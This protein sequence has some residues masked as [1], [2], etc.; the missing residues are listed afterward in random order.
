[1]QYQVATLLRRRCSFRHGMEQKRLELYSKGTWP[2]IFTAHWKH[3]ETVVQPCF[4]IRCS[5]DNAL[6]NIQ[7]Y[8]KF[9]PIRIELIPLIFQVHTFS[10]S[11]R[12]RNLCFVSSSCFL[13]SNSF[14]FIFSFSRFTFF[15]CLFF[16]NSSCSISSVSGPGIWDYV[17]NKY[18]ILKV[19]TTFLLNNCSRWQISTL[20]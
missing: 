8:I 15:C 18:I 7:K 16:S 14:L 10:L 11:L 13:S 4:K 9:I 3:R 20:L 6:C 1:M 12:L 17:P 5:A 2:T 19:A